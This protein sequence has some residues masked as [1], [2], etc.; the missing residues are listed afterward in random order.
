MKTKFYNIPKEQRTDFRMRARETL[1]A[2]KANH[3]ADATRLTVDDKGNFKYHFNLKT[4]L[5][6]QIDVTKA[7]GLK[8]LFQECF[9]DNGCVSLD[10]SNQ[11]WAVKLFESLTSKAN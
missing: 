3:N 2:C 5:N 6:I 9:D 7:H 4:W 10:V 11:Q 1:V 8:I